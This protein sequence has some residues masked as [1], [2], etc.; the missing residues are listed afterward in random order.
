MTE[1]VNPF[2]MAQKQFD[3]VADM[4]DL[5]EEVRAYLRYQKKNFMFEF[6]SGWIMA[7]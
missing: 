3:H 5:D 7:N 4:L 2:E 6:L 1:V